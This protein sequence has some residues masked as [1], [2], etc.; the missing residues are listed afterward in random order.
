V[1]YLRGLF[2]LSLFIRCFTDPSL[3]RS[4]LDFA[5]LLSALTP[6]RFVYIGWTVPIIQYT[7]RKGRKRNGALF[8]SNASLVLNGRV[9]QTSWVMYSYYSMG[10][11][12]VQVHLHRDHDSSIW[13]H[14][15]AEGLTRPPFLWINLRSD[16][17]HPSV[18]SRIAPSTREQ[19]AS[20]SNSCI[21]RANLQHRFWSRFN[22]CKRNVSTPLSTLRSI[23][24]PPR[25]WRSLTITIYSY[26]SLWII[27]LDNVLNVQ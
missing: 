22:Q 26:V 13:T 9:L 5:K 16:A 7:Q 15:S 12:L 3:H 18:I 21:H 8:F 24:P 4:N 23:D 14:S 19:S 1:F 10:S 11:L 2:G 20:H 27:Y 17:F 25:D 6:R